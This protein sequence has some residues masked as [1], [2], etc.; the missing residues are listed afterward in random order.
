MITVIYTGTTTT[1]IAISTSGL[2]PPMPSVTIQPR[3][4]TM[5]TSF[6]TSTEQTAIISNTPTA[7]ISN[8]PTVVIGNVESGKGIHTYVATCKF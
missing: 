1:N 8:T 4:K 2:G 3:P 7:I 6:M 5:E